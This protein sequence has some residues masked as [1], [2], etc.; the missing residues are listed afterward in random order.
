MPDWLRPATW[1]GFAPPPEISAKR[2]RKSY[3]MRQ[4]KAQLAVMGTSTKVNR[5]K[6]ARRAE[7]RFDGAILQAGPP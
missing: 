1:L 6:L 7:A 4:M 3:A 2:V 5:I